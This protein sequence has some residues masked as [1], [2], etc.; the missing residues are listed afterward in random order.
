MSECDTERRVSLPY[1]APGSLIAK[2]Y[3][4]IKI[5]GQGSAGSVYL[6]NDVTKPERCIALKVLSGRLTDDITFIE[7]FYREGKVSAQIKSPYVVRSYDLIMDDGLFAYTMEYV[8][9]KSLSERL[10][11]TPMPALNFVY[12][13][14][15]HI[16]KGLTEIH[17]ADLV[18]RDLKPSNVLITADNKTKIT[19]FG[20]VYLVKELY[21]QQRQSS[22][23][24]NRPQSSSRGNSSKAERLTLAGDFIGTIDYVSPEYVQFGQLDKRSD[25]YALGIVGFQMLTGMLPFKGEGVFERLHARVE[26]PAPK[27]HSIRRDVPN[28]LCDLVMSCLETNPLNRPQFAREISIALSDIMPQ[29]AIAFAKTVEPY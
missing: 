25:I 19:D 4:V 29:S 5:L 1:Y 27:L 15:L 22:I 20:I 17:K 3:M 8:A 18:H 24:G 2:R 16:S 26:T 21:G 12:Q 14:L 28:S 10:A 23:F 7:R 6:C 11:E 9:G 13:A